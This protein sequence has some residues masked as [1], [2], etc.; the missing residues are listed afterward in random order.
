MDRPLHQSW[1]ENC[2]SVCSVHLLNNCTFLKKI[3]YR[4]INEI[5]GNVKSTD[6]SFHFLSDSS[7]L[8]NDSLCLVAMLFKKST[9][10]FN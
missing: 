6:P 7:T 9:E 1:T 5:P 10:Y 8:K 3:I 2:N 4:K